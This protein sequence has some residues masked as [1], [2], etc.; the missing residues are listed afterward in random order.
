[1]KKA[2]KHFFLK[3]A[4]GKFIMKSL[5]LLNTVEGIIHLIVAGVGAWGL[6]DIGT[7]DIRAWT[8]V[9]ENFIFG[10]FSI[11]TGWALGISHHHHH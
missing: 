9:V 4:V 1:V 6:L 11:L 5:A 7:S 10:G 8:P 3:T 2:I